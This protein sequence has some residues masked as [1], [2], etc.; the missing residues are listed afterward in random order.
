MQPG[1][2]LLIFGASVRAAAFSAL[3]AGLMPWCVDL[4]ADADLRGLCPA[5]RLPGKY[6]D[7]FVDV[8]CGPGPGPWMYTGGLENHPA[9]VLELS[10]RR[11]LWG[12]DAAVLQCCRQPAFLRDVARDAGLPT[13]A[14]AQPGRVRPDGRWLLKPLFGAG[15]AGVRVWSGDRAEVNWGFSYLQEHVEGVPAA[16]LYVAAEHTAQ[17]LGV[18]RQLVGES[19]LF[20]P[21]F[22]YC[23]SVGPLPLPDSLGRALRR[24]G[25]RLAAE[26]SLRGLFGVD[27]ILHDGEFWP[28]EINPRYTASVEVLEHA[29]GLRAMHLHRLAFEDEPAALSSP[30]PPRAD[31]V[32]GKAILYARDDLAFPPQGPW[33]KT[34][35]APRPVE[36]LPDFA[37]LPHPDD[38]IDAGRPVLTMLVRAVSVE[39]CL[40]ALQARSAEVQ[41]CLGWG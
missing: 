2:Q 37:D 24:L 26:G 34:L 5:V 23:G 29:T 38:H 8:A 1:Q 21:A 33:R 13:P 27:G 20:A 17:L 35:D 4:F 12:N 22:G 10:S 32:V 14:L 15:G 36:E 7:S 25:H 39:E 40:A 30:V 9:L 11:P 19:W 31:S 16:A 6:P 18:T 3:R 28:V 41:A